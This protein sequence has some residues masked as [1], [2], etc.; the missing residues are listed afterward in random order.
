MDEQICENFRSQNNNDQVYQFNLS[1]QAESEDVPPQSRQLDRASGP[2]DPSAQ[3]EA[4]MNSAGFKSNPHHHITLADFPI[5]PS[6]LLDTYRLN[7][8]PDHIF[9]E[10]VPV[11]DMQWSGLPTLGVLSEAEML[12]QGRDPD[13]AAIANDIINKTL[14]RQPAGT[15]VVEPDSVLGESG[16]LYHG[17]K[18][19]KYLLPNDAV[20][21][22]SPSPF[23]KGYLYDL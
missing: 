14:N 17:Y 5:L 20:R 4:E 18:E 16:R 10:Q 19:G 9:A 7:R 23:R 1:S 22:N 12:Q 8:V 21:E 11:A 3:H 2:R 13:F 6:Q 15:S